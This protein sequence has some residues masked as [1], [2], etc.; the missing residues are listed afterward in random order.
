MV[1]TFCGWKTTWRPYGGPRAGSM[2]W[3]C[4]ENLKKTMEKV[5][6]NTW[7]TMENNGVIRILYNFIH[8]FPVWFWKTCFYIESNLTI[9]K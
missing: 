5:M 4:L 2:G 6:E 8:N 7:K 9:I 3:L 1:M